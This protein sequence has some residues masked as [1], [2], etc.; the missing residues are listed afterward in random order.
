MPGLQLIGLL[1]L[2]DLLGQGV[3][4]PQTDHPE[5]WLVHLGPARAH[6]L[7]FE[8]QKIVSYLRRIDSIRQPL[9][10]MHLL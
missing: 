1:H 10:L 3:L 9:Q 5:E 7:H 6:T 2:V 8:N 4:L